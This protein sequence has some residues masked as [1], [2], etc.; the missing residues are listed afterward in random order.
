MDL[1]NFI[2]GEFVPAES[3]ATFTKYSPFD[4]SVLA[5][6]ASSDAMDVIKTLQIAKKAAPLFKELSKENRSELLAKMAAY[7]E[8]NA[9]AI[10]YEEALHQGLSYSFVLENSVR[11]AVQI[12]KNNAQSLLL[13]SS[14]NI[15]QQPN[16]V[17]G[18]I[19]SWCLSLKL[20]IER[21]APALAAGNVVIIK[22]S[23]Q[24]PITAKILGEA[25]KAAHVPTGVI[26]ILQGGSDIAQVIAG[27]PSIHAVTAV[28]KTSTM[29]SIAKAGLSQFKKM[30]LNGSAKNPAIV[31]ADTDYKNLMPEILRPF[32]MGQGQLCW[33][34]SRIFVLES[35]AQDFLT[36]AKE[37]LSALTPLKDPRGSEV[38][39]PL[40]SEEAIQS[41]DAKIRGGVE[42]HGKVF[43]GGTR[44]DGPGY[45]Y[46]P[47]VML[48]LPNCSVLQ[49]DELQG[50]LLLITP[51][52]YQH[53][54]L[55]WANTSYL[56]HSGVVWGPSE[57][58]MK[59]ISQLECAHVWVNSWTKG[60]TETIFG[61]K[62]SSFGNPEMSWSGSFYSD[63]KKLAGT[64]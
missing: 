58:V 13:G 43:V 10:A 54:A 20:V 38:W 48:D 64:L 18:L 49:Q 25:A 39:T 6:V 24:S 41:I 28:G 17:M 12:L 37:Y 61:H 32:L 23:E 45:F 47:T 31:L 19:T 29:E 51:V 3:K 62:Q 42:E 2:G 50:P 59:V 57:K 7:L 26:N 35:F 27:H 60:E 53:E 4:G 40:I 56:A 36:V 9:E 22:I 8:Q 30:Q 52:K 5:Q 44:H 55:K 11:P 21:L 16:G 63:V 34:I 46:K 1:S 33:N 15:L 14:I